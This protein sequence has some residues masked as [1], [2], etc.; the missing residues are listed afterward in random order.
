MRPEIEDLSCE[1]FKR[2]ERYMRNKGARILEATKSKKPPYKNYWKLMQNADRRKRPLLIVTT[3]EV[4]RLSHFGCLDWNE[5]S[6][7][8]LWKMAF[9]SDA[10][11]RKMWG[12][13]PKTVA[14]RRRVE[15][16]VLAKSGFVRLAML[17][18]RG[19]GPLSQRDVNAAMCFLRDIENQQARS[20]L[21]MNWDDIANVRQNHQRLQN[22]DGVYARQSQS[23]GR[24]KA[25]VRILSEQDFSILYAACVSQLSLE[26]IEM[27]FGL[28]KRQA[29]I[30]LANVLGCVAN[31][32]DHQIKGGR[33]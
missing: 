27:K 33:Y 18:Q 25:L 26:A 4:S 15:G 13:F 12:N 1:R 14:G 30:V 23:E 2:I 31:A 22:Y 17:A 7:V 16:A 21:V 6:G 5:E 29:G 8:Y 9:D 19:E 24:I 32:Y 28:G 3:E 10:F 20:G 11:I